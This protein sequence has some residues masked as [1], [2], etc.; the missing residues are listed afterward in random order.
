VPGS[1]RAP[2]LPPDARRRAIV[3]AVAP[4]I[5]AHGA[6]V[7]TK[8]MADAAGVAEGTLFTVFADKRALVMAVLEDRL[9]PAPLTAALAAVDPDAPLPMVLTAVAAI[10]LPRIEEVR[11]LASALHGLPSAPRRTR[12]PRHLDAWAA[13][14]RGGVAALLRPHAAELRWS[15]ERLAELFAGLLFV[16]RPPWAPSASPFDGPELVDLVL[17]GAVGDRTIGAP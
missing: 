12:D 16:S 3:D 11:A 5:V 4:L 7:T 6:A 9:D 14:I 1:R 17:H 2:P 10:V 13:A 8:R 15:P